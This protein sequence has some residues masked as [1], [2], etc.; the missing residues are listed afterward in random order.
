LIIGADGYLL[1]LGDAQW[2]VQNSCM[3]MMQ[4]IDN[5]KVFITE[6]FPGGTVLAVN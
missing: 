6:K 1:I 2:D 4:G 3:E 5:W